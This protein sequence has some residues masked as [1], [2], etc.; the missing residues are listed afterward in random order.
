MMIKTLKRLGFGF[1]LAGVSASVYATPCDTVFSLF[2]SCGGDPVCEA[3]YVSNHPECFGGGGSTSNTQI[4]ATAFSQASAVSRA[5]AARLVTPSGGPV[6]SNEHQPKGLAAGGKPQAWNLWA[7]VD[8]NNTDF[9]YFAN[10][11]TRTGG[12][13]ITN[14]VFGADYTLSPQMVAGLSVALDRGDGWG[15]ATGAAKNNTNTDGYMIAPYLGYQLNK[16]LVLDVSAGFGQGDYSATGAVS[17]EADRWFAAANLSYARWMGNWQF[18]G[19]ASYLHGEEEYGQTKVAGV[20]QA[21]TASTNKLDQLRLNAHAGLWMNGYM[22]YVG[23]GYTSNMHRSS[24]IG[25]DPLGRDSFVMT[26]GVNFFSLSS[27]VSGGIF[28]EQELNRTHSDNEVISA[29]INFRF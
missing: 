16:D 21:N 17:A 12:T 1:I 2:S 14:S 6:A 24:D 7:N 11:A 22:P 15:Q 26:L 29:N 5:I 18:T 25:N 9:S 3:S 23:L 19:K 10:A 27:K 4:T 28:Y 20:A 8:Q 13:E